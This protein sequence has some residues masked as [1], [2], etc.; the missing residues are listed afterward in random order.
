MCVTGEWVREWAAEKWRWIRVEQR[1]R[2]AVSCQSGSKCTVKATAC[3]LKKMLQLVK[4]KKSHVCC[5][6][7]CWKSEGGLV[8]KWATMGLPN[9]KMPNRE[10]KN[11]EICSCWDLSSLS[12]QS[13]GNAELIT[14]L[15]WLCLKCFSDCVDSAEY[16]SSYSLLFDR[17]LWLGLHVEVMTF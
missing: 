15:V 3:Q 16:W 11:R 9:L 10:I 17:N 13:G 12:G 6:S 4:T 8:S 5:F 1:T 2:L 14:S 7:N